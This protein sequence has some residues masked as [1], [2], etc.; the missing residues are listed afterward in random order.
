MHSAAAHIICQDAPR[1]WER[2]PLNDGWEESDMNDENRARA[3]LWD[4]TYQVGV[5]VR[6]LDQAIAFY[7]RLGIGPFVDGP[8]A[9]SVMRKVYGEDAPDVRVSAR[10]AQMGNIEFE[11]LQP[12]A[13]RSVQG[14]FIAEHGEGVVHICAYTDDLDRDIDEM[15]ELGYEVISQGMFDDGG[16]FAYFDTREVGGLVLELFQTGSSWQ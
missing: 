7:E 3:D 13:G 1:K 5:A 11:L 14:D 6:D 4:R 8:S 9:H 15:T 2:F 10:I 12:V 16:K